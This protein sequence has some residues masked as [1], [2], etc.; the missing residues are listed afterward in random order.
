MAHDPDKSLEGATAAR[1]KGVGDHTRT[2]T[3]Q[4]ADVTTTARDHDTDNYTTTRT[5][6]SYDDDNDR[7]QST[8]EA[9]LGTGRRGVAT[10]NISWGAIFAGVV[11]FIAVTLLLSLVTAALGL[12]GAGGVATGIWTVVSLAIAL[13]A[14]GYVAGALAVRSGLLHGFLTWATS[15]VVGLL[16][17][18]W[19][20]T[21]LLG[22]VGGVVG[23]TATTVAESSGGEVTNEVQ[24]NVD[25]GAVDDAQQQAE[26]VIDDAQAQADDVADATSSAS[27]WGFAGLLLGALI[28][29]LAGMLGA[30]SVLGRE[31]DDDDDNERRV[32]TTTSRR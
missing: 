10:P 11:T 28:A 21:T 9:L 17:V 32:V 7:D 31:N 22:A 14:A 8:K 18:G 29:S 4:D 23:Q 20:G 3:V 26:D 2:A 30:K 27:W 6:R 24:E 12:G 19:L 16:M 5:T 13:A 25:Q 15:L 1:A